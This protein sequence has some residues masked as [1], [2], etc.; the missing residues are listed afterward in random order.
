MH[1]S[2]LIVAGGSGLRMNS[3][4]PKQFLLIRNMPIL[5]HTIIK[6]KTYNE[7]IDVRIVIPEAQISFW[8]DLCLKYHFKIKHQIIS[9]GENR[10]HSVKNGLSSIQ[11]DGLIAI[12]DGVRPLVSKN[13]IQRCF[14]AAEK[15]GAAIP[16]VDVIDTLREQKAGNSYTVNRANYKI[17]QTPQ[18]FKNQIIL[19][20][21]EQDFCESFTDD[22]SVVESMGT[23][24][25]MVDGNVEN[26]KITKPTDIKI[27]EAI[28]DS[29]PD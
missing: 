19:K 21:Y 20:A 7:S 9:G 18:V 25:T 14:S 24:I 27:A 4:I 12:H 23:Q 29:S 1:Q 2:V 22:A 28:M 15:S 3:N 10:F 8:K 5:M 13:T 17:V 6:F 11:E 16:V 26:I